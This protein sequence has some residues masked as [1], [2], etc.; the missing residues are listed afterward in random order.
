MTASPTETGV[1]YGQRLLD[2][3]NE[4]GDEVA[5]VVVGAD[6]EVELTWSQ[7]EE[8]SCRLGRV[9]SQQ[10]VVAGDRV[11]LELQNSAELVIA[12]LATWKVGGVPVPMRWDLPDW[13]RQRLLEV[14]SAKLE[15]TGES[16]NALLE[17]ASTQSSDPMP[18][19]V[20]PQGNG[21]C[22]SGST[23]MPKVIVSERPA[24]WVPATSTPFAENWRPVPRPQRILVPAPMYHTNGFTTLWFLMGG[25]Q[26]FILE[27]FDA[28]LFVDVVERHRIST[29][30]ATPTMLQRIAALPDID[31]RD[32]SS[33]VWFLQGAAV[34]PPSLL[35][36]WFELLSPEQIFMAYG[37][38]EQLGLTA[39]RGDEW[40]THEGSIGRGFRDTE[41]RILSPEGEQ[42]ETGELG[43]I[44]L[45]SPMTG[46]Y[47]YLG[48]AA[49][50]PV[51]EDGFGTAGDIGW[52]DEDGYLYLADRRVDMIVTG[53]ANVYPAEV[54]NALVDHPAIADVVVI[55][56]S[57]P[58]W[59]RR[60]HAIIQTKSALDP[61]DVI[62]Y[63]KSRL[64]GYKVPKSVEFVAEIPRSAATKVN[65]GALVAERDG[66]ATA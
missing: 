20:S 31:S 9:F 17:A 5:V 22:S 18:V 3:A 6:R 63:A 49:L 37:M 56:L 42:M 7:L 57:D 12:F 25:D 10:G 55:G 30:T 24:V 11:A 60:V 41:I 13:E 15:V 61:Q 4:R 52:L 35:R 28:A 1:P 8:Q 66:A 16:I 34:M 59:G 40:L 48:G 58:E 32:F 14:V 26:L 47:T 29:W 46:S 43:D 51:T 53:G 33:I 44:Y 38:T 62:T 50:L 27:K 65:R 19:A 39:L 2:L 23:G 21:I 36:R 45:R 64:A 54:E